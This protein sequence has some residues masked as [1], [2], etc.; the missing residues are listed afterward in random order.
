MCS[1]CRHE[2]AA[3]WTKESEWSCIMAQPTRQDERMVEM[4]ALFPTKHNSIH[5][6]GEKLHFNILR[7][8]VNTV[9]D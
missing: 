9:Y 6:Y 1:C 4:V 3:A 7:V 8:T 2:M 5:L